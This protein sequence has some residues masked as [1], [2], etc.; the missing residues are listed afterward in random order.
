MNTDGN[1]HRKFSWELKLRGSDHVAKSIER[2]HRRYRTSDARCT[3]TMALQLH[4]VYLIGFAAPGL[5]YSSGTRFPTYSLLI[6][7]EASSPTK[8]KRPGT[9]SRPGKWS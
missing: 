7:S 3:K 4:Q 1:S 2:W 8:P 9:G 5:R 6:S